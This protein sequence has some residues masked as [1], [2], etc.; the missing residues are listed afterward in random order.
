MLSLKQ[1]NRLTITVSG[2][3]TAS[4][5]R[6]PRACELV[7]QGRADW[8][9]H[10]V[11]DFGK[12][13]EI[14]IVSTRATIAASAE[15]YDRLKRRMLTSELKRIPF[16]G[17][18]DRMAGGAPKG[19]WAWTAAVRQNKASEVNGGAWLVEYAR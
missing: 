18:V 17:D 15:E 8:V 5:V 2:G 11:D 16:A 3:V 4:K 14:R 12:K 1:L 9:Y 10:P 19:T 13:P 6:F 7:Q